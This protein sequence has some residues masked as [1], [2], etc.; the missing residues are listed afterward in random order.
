MSSI[1]RINLS[2]AML[3]LM[4]EKQD[5]YTSSDFID[6]MLATFYDSFGE[7]IEHDSAGKR[8]VEYIRSILP[9]KYEQ[10][11]TIEGRLKWLVQL[12]LLHIEGGLERNHYEITCIFEN[13]NLFLNKY[14]IL[15]YHASGFLAYILTG[16]ELERFHHDV[17]IL[18]S[19]TEYIKLCKAINGSDFVVTENWGKREDGALRRV[20]HMF[21]KDYTIPISIILFDNNRKG[22]IINDYII[23][24]NE[25]YV[26][27]ELFSKNNV[28]L[29]LKKETVKNNGIPFQCLTLEAIYCSKMGG[30]IKN[31]YDSCIMKPYIDEEKLHNIIDT[32]KTYKWRERIRD[33]SIKARLK[34]IG[35]R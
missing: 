25:Y 20:I 18:M 2:D 14:N 29:C 26:D 24:N 28:D 21:Y 7:Y 15:F 16:C 5:N 32:S 3:K 34:L 13:L 10:A 19:E 11:G 35:N 30:G 4:L 9:T 8:W 33:E 12:N 1:D 22:M 17:D 31:V 23:I 6:E 27:R